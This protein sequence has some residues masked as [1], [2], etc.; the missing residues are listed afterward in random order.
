[1]VPPPP[2]RS[3]FT[4]DL[5]K[6]FNAILDERQRTF[7]SRELVVLRDAILAQKIDFAHISEYGHHGTTDPK[8]GLKTMLNLFNQMSLYI[9][10]ASWGQAA[11][12]RKGLIPPVPKLR[13]KTSIMGAVKA[14]SADDAQSRKFSEFKLR[15]WVRRTL[16]AVLTR[17]LARALHS[18]NPV[19]VFD[20]WLVDMRYPDDDL[21]R[22]LPESFMT[23]CIARCEPLSPELQREAEDVNT[24]PSL[25]LMEEFRRQGA[26]IRL[27][28][29]KPLYDKGDELFQ[30]ALKLKGKDRE[31]AIMKSEEIWILS[32]M[33][34]PLCDS[35][36]GKMARS[37]LEKKK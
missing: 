4:F 16:S 10:E 18:L 1:M 37:A 12:I 35:G 25:A 9:M 5:S 14:T 28:A 30:M 21:L 7:M 23:Q 20:E 29:V 33:C 26:M 36:Y 15:K 3:N 6:P 22:R 8:G 17:A 24:L 13:T 2:P 34:G 19:K 31:F 32:A 27:S 11:L